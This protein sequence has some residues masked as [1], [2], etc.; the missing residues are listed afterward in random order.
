MKK[1]QT[2]SFQALLITAI[3]CVSLIIISVFLLRKKFDKTQWIRKSDALRKRGE[4]GSVLYKEKIFIFGG[5]G[6]HP[7]IESS[8]EVYDILSGKWAFINSFP[9]G[10]KVTHHGTVLIDDKIWIIG[11]RTINNRGPIT[12]NVFI[13]D[14]AH[15]SWQQ[16]PSLTDPKTSKPIRW[17]AGGAVLLGRTL[18]VFGGIT[19]TMCKGDQDKY[20]L[21]LDIDKWLAD[22]KNTA[23]KNDL[24]PMPLKR[25]HLNTAV[26]KGRI[27]AIGGQR[28]HDCGGGKEV[29]YVHAY[30]PVNDNWIRLTNLPSPRSHSEGGTFIMDGKIYVVGGQGYYNLAKNTVIAFT[31][32]TNYGMGSWEGLPYYELPDYYLGISAK[33]FKNTLIISHGSISDIA[34][35]RRETFVLPIKRNIPSQLGFSADC[36]NKAIG[37]N[38]KTDISNIIYTVEGESGYT[39][40]SDSPWLT[41]TKNA[42]GSA[43]SSGT[44]IRLSIDGAG[45]MPGNYKGIITATS[46]NTSHDFSGAKFCVNI[47]VTSSSLQ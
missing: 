21:T 10:K 36:I 17:A 46:T 37:Q 19:D 29:N 3:A 4:C 6:E 34:D 7:S 15:N 9:P 14:I 23:W 26:F 47:T 25:N 1:P 32:E 44:D 8:N 43:T 30:D 28:G 38:N 35:E 22:P 18:H 27:Y 33:V 2:W 42:N 20:H 31:P 24:M 41:V 39:L 45:L 12:S 13:Y 11:G 40:S 16:G 5:F